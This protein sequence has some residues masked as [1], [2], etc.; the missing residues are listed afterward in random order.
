[1]EVADMIKNTMHLKSF[2]NINKMHRL[3]RHIQ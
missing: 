3:F 1:M 2:Q